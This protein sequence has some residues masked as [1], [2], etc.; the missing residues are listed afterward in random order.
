MNGKEVNQSLT[1]IECKDA[2][3]KNDSN[4]RVCDEKTRK[5]FVG[6]LPSDVT[7]GKIGLI[8]IRC[9]LTFHNTGVF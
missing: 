6:G 1:E 9:A 8:K 3:S 4:V 7:E 2:I 5:V